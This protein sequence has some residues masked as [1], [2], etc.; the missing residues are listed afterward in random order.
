MRVDTEGF[1]IISSKQRGVGLA[2]WGGSWW[3]AVSNTGLFDTN[4]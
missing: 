4:S 2:G 1:E 3:G